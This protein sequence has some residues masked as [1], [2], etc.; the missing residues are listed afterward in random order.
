MSENDSKTVKE[1]KTG[2]DSVEGGENVNFFINIRE[3]RFWGGVEAGCNKG[4]NYLLEGNDKKAREYFIDRSR[5]GDPVSMY[6]LG[7]MCFEGLGG[8]KDIKEAKRLFKEVALN[9]NVHAHLG[10]GI[11]YGIEENW[12]E[13]KAWL[14]GASLQSHI[15]ADYCLGLIYEYG[16]GEEKNYRRAIKYYEKV[17]EQGYNFAKKRLVALEEKLKFDAQQVN[18]DKNIEENNKIRM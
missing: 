10:L 5:I 17:E 3:L 14:V 15:L 13:A 7:S 1:K 8:N 9:R 11:I 2:W 16:L 6:N 4:E 18:K 12:G